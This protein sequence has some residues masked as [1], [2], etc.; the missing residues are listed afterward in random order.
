MCVRDYMLL[1]AG[2]LILDVASPSLM[3][4]CVLHWFYICFSI[5]VVCVGCMP[6]HDLSMHGMGVIDVRE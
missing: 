5:I 3:E 6:P 2:L 4:H 1:Y